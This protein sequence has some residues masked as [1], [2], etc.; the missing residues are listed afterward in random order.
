MLKFVNS[1]ALDGE[2]N[3]NNITSFKV[4]SLSESKL[5]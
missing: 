4:S 3:A 1:E 5:V 2:V